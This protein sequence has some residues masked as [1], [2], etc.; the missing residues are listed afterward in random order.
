ML[1]RDMMLVFNRYPHL[2]KQVTRRRKYLAA[3]G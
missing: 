1:F 2:S 3:A